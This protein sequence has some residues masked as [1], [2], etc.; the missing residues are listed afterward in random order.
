MPIVDIKK[1]ESMESSPEINPAWGIDKESKRIF[2]RCGIC[3]KI[4]ALSH[5]HFIDGSGAITPMMTHTE[6]GWHVSARLI[7]YNK[8]DILLA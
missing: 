1:V 4:L 5:I 2:I 3:K 7:N 6:C 8:N